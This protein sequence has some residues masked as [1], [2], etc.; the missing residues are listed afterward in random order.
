MTKGVILYALNNSEIEYTSLAEYNARRINHFLNVPVSIITDSASSIKDISIFDK[1]IEI[2]NSNSYYLRSFRDGNV[3]KK[4]IWKN[5]HR[6]SVYDLSPYE[7]TLVLDVDYII[8]S[9][10]LNYCWDQPS[11]FLIYKNSKDLA[12]W[13]YKD[14][15]KYVS[16]YSIPFYWA[17]AFFFR[18]TKENKLLFTLISHI[19]DNWNYY[20]FSYQLSSPN[21][22]NDYAFSIAIHIMNGMTN[23]DF[24]KEFPGYMYYTLDR[25]ILVKKSD[26]SFVFLLQKNDKHVPAKVSDLDV[27]I[28]NKYSL[29]RSIKDE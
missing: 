22:R 28:M 12:S 2:S 15:P 26:R 6:D 14:I 3:V 17:T 9:N 4:D 21:F 11:N 16:Q 18:K 27:H 25:D 13:R 8:N 23:G 1:V 5:S 10:I 20:N 29:L 24:A 7:N 19:K